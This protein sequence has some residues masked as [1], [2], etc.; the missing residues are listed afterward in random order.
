MTGCL[1]A[2]KPEC[3]ALFFVTPTLLLGH[4]SGLM[5][6]PLKDTLL[7]VFV[8]LTSVFALRKYTQEI[9]DDI[10]DKSVFEWVPAVLVFDVHAA[11][12]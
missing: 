6:G 2:G 5:P 10:G 8:L 11:R 3:A 4:L 1:S 7:A 12:L 9:K